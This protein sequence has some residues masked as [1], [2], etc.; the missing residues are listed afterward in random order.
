VLDFV[1]TRLNFLCDGCGRRRV[2]ADVRVTGDRRKV[3]ED[4]RYAT[5]GGI[6]FIFFL[7]C[8]ALLTEM[9]K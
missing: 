5:V 2:A 1:G 7:S 6:L 4:A 9:F 3:I 8:S